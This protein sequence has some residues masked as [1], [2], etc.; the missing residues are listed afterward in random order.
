MSLCLPNN[1]ISQMQ[2]EQSEKKKTPW[3]T[4]STESYFRRIGYQELEGILQ[5]GDELCK[6]KLP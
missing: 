1:E 2:C 6:I 4:G 5:M 3:V